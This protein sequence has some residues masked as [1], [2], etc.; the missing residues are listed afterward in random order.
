[1]NTLGAGAPFGEIALLTDQPRTAT[2]RAE[3]GAEVMR[4][5]R[6]RFLDLVQREPH[7]AVAIA[8]TLSQRLRAANAPTR[9]MAN[10]TAVD[11]PRSRRPPLETPTPT[12]RLVPGSGREAI[13]AV[14]AGCVLP[15]V[16]LLPPPAGLTP[17]GWRA[18]GV[19]IAAVPAL[20]LDALPDGV[21]ALGLA[22]VWVLGGIAPVSAVPERTGFG[23]RRRRPKDAQTHR[24]SV[25]GVQ[26]RDEQRRSI[27]CAYGSNG[28]SM[29][30]WGLT[31]SGRGYAGRS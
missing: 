11:V 31:A 9:A 23:V 12:R 18:L 4:L 21:L 19:L 26:R 17:T 13:G 22:A 28:S 8:A 24:G 25:A 16:W 27:H 2:V 30:G 1:V 14:I 5:D 20:A 7:V 15:L 6:G 3:T 10:D 29:R